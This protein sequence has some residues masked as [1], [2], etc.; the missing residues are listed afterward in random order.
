MKLRISISKKTI[1]FSIL[2]IV[3]CVAF[4]K[5]C[6]WDIAD[7]EL[8]NYPKS[9]Q[10]LLSSSSKYSY[11]EAASKIRKSQT[12]VVIPISFD[13]PF[14]VSIQSDN[15]IITVDEDRYGALKLLLL[16][17]VVIPF[18]NLLAKKMG[19]SCIEVKT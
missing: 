2:F 6:Q 9:I 11:H 13:I 14:T 7:K 10:V 8:S 12:Y 19:I 5:I 15:D 17:I 1:L 16:S 18:L 4:Q 3:I